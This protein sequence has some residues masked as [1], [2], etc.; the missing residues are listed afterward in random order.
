MTHKSLPKPTDLEPEPWDSL[1]STWQGDEVDGL[2]S[3]RSDRLKESVE[4]GRRSAK[5]GRRQRALA[6]LFVGGE[7]LV[8]LI[9][10]GLSVHWI[11]FGT[12]ELR[13]AAFFV[14]PLLVVVAWMRR[15]SW[16]DR[17]PLP[18]LPPGRFIELLIERNG[19]SYQAL[20]FGRGLAW[21]EIVFF[22]LWIP[23]AQDF[24]AARFMPRL[25]GL[26][27]FMVVFFGALHMARTYLDREREQLLHLRRELGVDGDDAMG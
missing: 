21:V 1:V 2:D 15:R 22:I 7:I 27:L 9:F 18:D 19:A 13:G 17:R 23:W 5:L 20:R 6:L 3:N 11:L 8:C 24:D 12:V 14:L 4:L 25:A 26:G 10:A 16:R